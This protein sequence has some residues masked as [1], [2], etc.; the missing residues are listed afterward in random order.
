MA[1]K[2]FALLLKEK[3]YFM[4]EVMYLSL[5]PPW[6]GKVKLTTVSNK[7]YQAP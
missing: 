7:R 6:Q 5:P 3:T 1:R 2:A 4:H